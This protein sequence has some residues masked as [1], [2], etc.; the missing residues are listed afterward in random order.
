MLKLFL[1]ALLSLAATLFAIPH[2]QAQ[3]PVTDAEAYAVGVEAY[4]YFYSLITMEVTRRQLTNYEPGKVPGHGPTNT[5]ANI[6]TFPDVNFRVVVRPNFDTLYSSAWMDVQTEPVILSLPSSNG[7]YYLM[8]L[9][10]MW[11]DVFAVPGKRTSGTQAQNYA[12]TFN[13]KGKLPAGV[14]RIE[15]PTP[16]IWMIGRTQTNGPADYPNV[17]KFQEQIKITPLSQWGKPPKQID[18]KPDPSID[19]KTDPL[20]TVNSMGAAEFL[21]KAAELVKIHP[22]HATDWSTIARLKRIGFVV[23]QSYD[24]NKQSATVQ[25][26]VKRATKEALATMHQKIP[27][28]ARVVNG[29][30][31]NTDT[32][33]VYGNYYLKRSIV[34]MVGLGANQP[35][36][37]VYPLLLTDSTGQ[38][39]KGES[40]YVLHFEKS[41]L[42]PVTAFWSLTMY[43]EQGYPIANPINRYAI[44]DRDALKYN[45]DGS[46]DLYIQNTN[47]GPNKVSNWLPS[48]DKGVLGLTMRLYGPK[49]IVVNGMWAP[50]ALV[51]VQ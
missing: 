46:L 32:M 50:P 41:Q 12:I 14:E 25:N 49:Q 30:Q 51:R 29:W 5:V 42:P 48:P 20:T 15:A 9:L 27:T 37:A 2:A 18:F 34:S 22:P 45:A 31:M 3:Q 39:V 16:I 17:N 1:C 35:E 6:L 44:G 10:D 47:P 33:G 36:D 19:M 38:Q 23:G 11:T 8:P 24:L 4:N 26:A 43:D 21:A 7:R 28:L 40:N 13:W